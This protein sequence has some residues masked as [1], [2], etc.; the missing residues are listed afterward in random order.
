MANLNWSDYSE[1]IFWR[2]A[3]ISFFTSCR[4]GELLPDFE[5]GFDPKTTV[6]W[7]NVKFLREKEAIIYVPFCKTKGFKGKIIYIYHLRNYAKC[8]IAALD[9]LRKL[10]IENDLFDPTR[11]VFTLKS[12][13]I[14]TKNAFNKG[15]EFL[16]EDFCDE[17]HKITRHSFRAAIPTLISSIPDKC[18]VTEL[19]E[20]GSW[21]SNSFRAYEKD[22]RE[23]KRMLFK[24]F[25]DNMHACELY[26]E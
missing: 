20:W 16:L 10:A 7:Q 12:G 25:V 14:F 24:K 3:S 15:L 4:M 1:Q 22:E 9:K 18:T 2:A 11:P 19:K 17:N 23:K 8:P 5:K 26:D 13:K 6:L 21:E